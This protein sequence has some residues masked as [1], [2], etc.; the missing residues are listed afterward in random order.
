MKC[1]EAIIFI[2][3]IKFSWQF[4]GILLFENFFSNINAAF[5]WVSS[6]I[7]NIC[8]R[9]KENGFLKTEV[10]FYWFSAWE[11]GSISSAAWSNLHSCFPVPRR[12]PSLWGY[13]AFSVKI[14]Q[15]L[16]FKLLQLTQ[17]NPTFWLTHGGCITCIKPVKT[18]LQWKKWDS[19][20]PPLLLSVAR[21]HKN[22][23]LDQR[24]CFVLQHFATRAVG[25]TSQLQCL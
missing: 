12:V 19:F 8:R 20:P 1:W 4:W 15:I 17:E 2:S 6:Y 5:Y 14:C 7:L 13:S 18:A 23:F 9:T 24:T 11:P 21:E 3:C 16:L 25:S 22:R 10:F